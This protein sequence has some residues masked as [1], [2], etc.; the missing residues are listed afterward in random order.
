L[1][2]KMTQAEKVTKIAEILKRRF[3]NLNALELIDIAY[4]ILVGIEE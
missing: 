2:E 3:P 4:K 1:E